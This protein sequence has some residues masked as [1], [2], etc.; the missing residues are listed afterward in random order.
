MRFALFFG[1]CLVMIVSSGIGVA[2]AQEYEPRPYMEQPDTREMG[3]EQQRSRQ[4]E[5]R[6]YDQQRS[7]DY[8]VEDR[9]GYDEQKSRGYYDPVQ[10]NPL[11]ERKTK[12][13]LTYINGGVGI[14]QRESISRVE[15]EF[16]LKLVFADQEGRY[17]S[18]VNVELLDNEGRRVFSLDE[19]G[20]W[21]LTELP[22]GNYRVR[23]SFN[24]EEKS[25][26]VD[27][28]RE[29]IRTVLMQW[30]M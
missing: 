12:D 28:G 21:L 18:D 24:G 10:R 5:V 29:G 27:I 16:G 2:V 8:G 19:A 25:R 30:P 4:N 9:K 1:I 7:G 11:V 22:P 15:N 13:G 20:P 26:K 6:T 17:I 3:A 14:Q 23:A